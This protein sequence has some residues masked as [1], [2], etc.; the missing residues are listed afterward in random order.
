MEKEVEKSL[1]FW[2]DCYAE[3]KPEVLKEEDYKLPDEMQPIFNKL[4]DNC[5]VIID[6]GCGEGRMLYAAA[7]SKKAK[8]LYGI[9]RGSNIVKYLNGMISAN[10]FT[11]D[12]K[13]IDGGI[14][15]L[16]NFKDNSVGG[17]IISNVF[18]IVTE[19]VADNIMKNLLRVLKKDGYMMMKLNQYED[20][21]KLE[22]GK[23][24]NFT[25]NL[26]S[27]EG[28]MRLRLLTTDQWREWLKPYFEEEMYADVP[29]QKEDFFDRLFLL[30]K[31]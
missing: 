17:I 30:R 5:P 20:K 29:Y 12:I 10:N 22:K 26:Y 21:E 1:S 14:E 3:E 25:D 7:H 19:D 6:Y 28:V 18:D 15:A 4:L 31:K 2:N 16:N 13:I 8:E 27:Y 11:D 23:M 9:E 24:I